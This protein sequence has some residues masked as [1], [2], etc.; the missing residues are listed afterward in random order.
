MSKIIN[1]TTPFEYKGKIV[2]GT[3]KQ[4]IHKQTVQKEVVLLDAEID[5]K[6]PEGYTIDNFG[7]YHKSKNA[8]KHQIKTIKQPKKRKAKMN[9]KIEIAP[10]LNAYMGAMFQKAETTVQTE[11]QRT[12]N[13]RKNKRK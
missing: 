6:A 10:E 11:S 9:A 1:R 2:H 3:I 12:S 7:D 5:F 13:K 4:I 8:Y